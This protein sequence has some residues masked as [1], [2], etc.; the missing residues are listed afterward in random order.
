MTSKAKDKRD[1]NSEHKNSE[2]RSYA[3]NFDYMM[4]EWLLT[5]IR[6]YG[7]DGKALELG[8]FEGEFTEKISNLFTE[9]YAVEGSSKL[10]ETLKTRFQSKANIKIINSYFED[11]IP[12]FVFDKIFL[13]HTLEHI[14]D[15]IT[16]LSTARN[17]LSEEGLLVVMVPNGN[18]L[19]R[20]IAVK[21]GIISH[22]TAV[23]KGEYEHGHRRTYTIDVLSH[24]IKNA[25]YSI[26]ETGGIF[27]KGLAN[28]Q[29]D[30]ALM[31]N[32]I[33]KNYIEG[34][35][36]LGKLYP[37]FCSSIFVVAKRDV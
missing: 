14:D 32:I 6:N 29:L 12:K 37:D 36:E 18:A 7:F 26:V 3:Y 21:A 13:L 8:C 25:G 11:F 10:Y 17:W 22:N 27:L 30:K 4:H 33:D 20:Q 23:T 1:L 5:R 2:N 16:L 24:Q 19:S 34:C 9:V 15:P 31:H 28:F 35:L